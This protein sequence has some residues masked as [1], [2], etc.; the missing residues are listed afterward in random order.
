MVPAVPTS[1][2]L[3]NAVTVF[4]DAWARITA[5]KLTPEALAVT[6]THCALESGNFNAPRPGEDPE[7]HVERCFC[8]NYGNTRAATGED[9][10]VCQYRCNEIIGGK[11][12]WYD[13]PAPQSTFRAFAEPSDGAAAQLSFL[14]HS[15]RY[16]QAWLR[17]LAGDPAGYVE[18]LKRAG[19]FT[20]AI[21]PYETAVLSIF[22]RI[23]PIAERV[24]AGQPHGVTDEDRAHVSDLVALTLANSALGQSY[25][26]ESYPLDVHGVPV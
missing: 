19:Y 10:D 17:L 23:L 16:A 6:V 25:E 26:P 4:A 1:L 13:P 11:V 15:T 21:G 5:S 2:S 22:R 20:G 8:N 7:H 18:C 14:A 12:V 24:I 9:C 3:E